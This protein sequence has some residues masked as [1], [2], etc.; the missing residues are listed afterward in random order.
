MRIVLMFLAL[1]IA[2]LS[3]QEKKIVTK[4]GT[5]TFK[6][7]YYNEAGNILQE[8]FIKNKKLHGEWASFYKDGRKAV[9]GQYDKG[10]K[11]GK[12]FFWNQGKIREVDFVDNNVVKVLDW[13]TPATIATIDKD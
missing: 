3:A 7:V 2:G 11:V 4:E 12:W 1:S 6:V 8:G 9:S 5:N 10:K 13:D